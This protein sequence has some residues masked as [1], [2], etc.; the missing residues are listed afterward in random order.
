MPVNTVEITKMFIKM[1]ID[2]KERK[3]SCTIVTML[4]E[5]TTTRE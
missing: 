4:F 3:V 2:E 5:S 1:Y